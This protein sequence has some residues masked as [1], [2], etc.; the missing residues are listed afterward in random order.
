[1]RRIH[2]IFLII[3]IILISILCIFIHNSD[4]I[5]IQGKKIKI[6]T[7]KTQEQRNNGLMFR[8]SLCS[9]CGMLFIFEY[10]EIHSFWMKNTYIPL[11]IVFI[12]GDLEI[13]D[14]IHAEPCKKDPCQSY[15]SQQNSRY[16]LEVNQG[17][18]DE[19]IIGGRIDIKSWRF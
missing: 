3:F 8:K 11:D 12:N 18:F 10:E 17:L 13:F 4:Y 14:I 9:N 7:A 5:F 16:V 2:L 6:E 1:M 19:G 15:Q